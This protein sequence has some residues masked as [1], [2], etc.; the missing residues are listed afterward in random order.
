MMWLVKLPMKL[1][2]YRSLPGG[3]GPPARGF[4]KI[5]DGR[6]GGAWIGRSGG[7]GISRR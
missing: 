3:G 4:D 1:S 2:T 6:V 5:V 7:I